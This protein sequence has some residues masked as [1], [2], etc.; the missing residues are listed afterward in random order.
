[1]GH[2]ED[3]DI[4]LTVSSNKQLAM[5]ELAEAT[6]GFAVTNT[7]QIALPMQRVM[8]DIRTHYEVAYTPSATN[9]DGHFRKIEVRIARPHVTVQTRS[10]YFAVPELNG[11]PLQPFEMA[12]LKAMNLHPNPNLFP[13]DTALLRFRPKPS[14]ADYEMAFDVP[15]SS[16]RVVTDAKTGDG[17]VRFSVVA[18]IHKQNGEVVGKV[19]RDLVRQISHADL[20]RVES[21][22]ILYA[23]PI[24]LPAGHY[25]IDTAV[26]DNL[27]EKT[28]VKRLAAFVDSGKNLGISSLQLVR[29]IQSSPGPRDQQDPFETTSGRIVPTL[30]GSVPSGQPLQVYFLVYPETDSAEAPRITLQLFRN[31]EEV[32]T[33]DLAPPKPAPDGTLHCLLRMNPVPGQYDMLITARQGRLS[34]EARLAVDVTPS[35]EIKQ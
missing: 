12:A 4:Q 26:T 13:Y 21:E 10:G 16:L 9:Y 18:L 2:L 3:D 8:E 7:N 20:A 15:V 28:T 30:A 11:E 5:V 24:E 29:G 27:A 6:G 33:K 23:E 19:S 22:R 1:M 14:S 17:H 31:G 32:G 25:E 34:S 35:T